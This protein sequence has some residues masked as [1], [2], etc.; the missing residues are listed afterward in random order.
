MGQI[1]SNNYS[2]ITRNYNSKTGPD[3]P[4][5]S[6]LQ[7]ILSSLPT[8]VLKEHK[9]INLANKLGALGRAGALDY[10]GVSFCLY[11]R[12]MYIAA[13]YMP[14]CTYIYVA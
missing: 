13:V 11:M 1:T 4:Y 10:A 12:E 3:C 14:Q 2:E 6:L 5:L 9:K 7:T 8:I